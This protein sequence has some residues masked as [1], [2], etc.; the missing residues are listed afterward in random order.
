MAYVTPSVGRAG[1]Q[2][3]HDGHRVTHGPGAGPHDQRQHAVLDR[4]VLPAAHLAEVLAQRPRAAPAG[5]DSGAYATG[6]SR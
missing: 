1:E 3:V 5:T 4:D 2:L 6:S